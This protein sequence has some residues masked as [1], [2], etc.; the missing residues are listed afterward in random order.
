MSRDR[1]D[2]LNRFMSWSNQLAVREK[3]MP[4]EQYRWMLVKDFV[5]HFNAHRKDCFKP[6]SIICVDKS[7][8]RWYGM[9]GHWINE[10][11]PMYVAID[12][13]PEDRCEIQNSCCGISGI[14]FETSQVQCA[15]NQRS[16]SR[17]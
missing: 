12:R 14:I 16:T 4:S 7:M 13:K 1:C 17:K 15:W 2:K 10:G 11:L 6:S 8:S 5:D 3:G 9:G